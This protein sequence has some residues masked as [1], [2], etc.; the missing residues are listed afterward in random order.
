MEFIWSDSGDTS[1]AEKEVWKY[2][3][4]ALAKEK[5][6]CYH[7][8]P[9]FSADR[10]RREPDILILHPQWGLYVVNCK[11]YKIEN[12][13]K[14]DDPIWKMENW[15]STQE[16]PVSEAEDQL[17]AVLGKF[18]SESVLR[19]KRSDV[20]QGHIFVGLPFITRAQLKEKR[21]DLPVTSSFSIIFSDDLEPEALKSRLQD[22]P[23]QEKQEPLTEEQWKLALAVLQ[24]GPVLRR[25]LRPEASNRNSKAFMLR[26]VEQQML[27]IDRE[28]SKVAIQIPSGP[29][30][31]RGLSGSG[32]TVVCR[33]SW[34][35]RGR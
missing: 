15:Q 6:T 17:W 35:C 2:L 14:I 19:K 10:S 8:F 13:E 23:A 34:E 18:R 5:G 32:K 25:Q 27:S 24:G 3:K 1:F 21:L 28:Q 9:I 16:T 26:Q 22:I 33:R 7:R 31:I 20:I 11:G 4:I 30:R 12:I 29:Q